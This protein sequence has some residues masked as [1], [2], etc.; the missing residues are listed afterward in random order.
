VSLNIT[1]LPVA[2]P[3]S[4]LNCSAS[5]ATQ[6]TSPIAVSASVTFV[7][8][9]TPIAAGV[10]SCTLSIDNNDSNEHPYDWTISGNAG[11]PPAP[12]IDIF[13][14]AALPIADGGLDS[15]GNAASGSA[16]NLTYSIANT[17]T[18][19]LTLSGVPVVAV[20]GL[21]NCTVNIVAAP[22][23]SVAVSGS[24]NFTLEITPAA[25]GAFSVVLSIAN[26]DPNENPYDWTISG[27]GTTSGGGG[28][29][30]SGDGGCSASDAFSPWV[31]LA[32]VLAALCVA[33]RFRRRGA[34]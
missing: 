17:G 26:N 22:P 6:P 10:F 25:A 4:L 7:V 5:I 23:A 24:A 32:G 21:V 9:V 3:G 1:S 34:L 20:S 30:S 15:V 33:A 18:T 8:S 31:V 11:T 2:A 19:S 16:L 13:R 14:G 29:S 27:T 28:G 12:E